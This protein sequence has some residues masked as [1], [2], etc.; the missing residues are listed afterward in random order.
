MRCD[1]LNRLLT[2]YRRQEDAQIVYQLIA[3][4]IRCCPPCARGLRGPTESTPSLLAFDTLTCEQCRARFPGYYEATH[5]DHP[6]VALPDL[7][8]A[9]MALHL[10]RCRD[11][12]QQY[13]ALAELS[14]MEELGL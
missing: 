13:E 11:C 9:G 4:H 12:H 5:P 14:E 7:V 10:G 6:Q 8:I 2:I 1:E 3:T